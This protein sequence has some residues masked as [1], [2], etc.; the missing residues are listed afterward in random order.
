MWHIGQREWCDIVA[1]KQILFAL[2]HADFPIFPDFKT[3]WHFDDKLG[4]KYLF[5]GLQIP[6]PQAYA[7][8]NRQEALEWAASTAYPKVFKLRCGAGSSNVVLVRDQNHARKLISRAFGRGFPAYDPWFSLRERWRNFR[9]GK[10]GLMEPVKGC[11]RLLSPPAYSRNQGRELGYAYFQDFVPHNDSDTRVIVIADKAFAI[12]RYVRDHDFRASGS[13]DFGYAP[14]LFDLKCVEFAFE[15]TEKIQTQVGV[16]D[17]VFDSSK[18]PLLLEISFGFTAEGYDSCPGYWDRSL[19][20]HAGRF[21]PYGW[22]VES[23]LEKNNRS[24][25]LDHEH[26]IRGKK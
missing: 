24:G 20:W 8:Y 26:K 2:E 17:F 9:L 5:E 14:E 6:T 10:V 15:I 23:A 13:G 12:K 7:F 16:Y 3:A 1:S 21:N 25:L 11:L 4:Q 18:Q 19:F 22:M